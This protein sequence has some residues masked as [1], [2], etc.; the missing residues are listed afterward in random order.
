MKSYKKNFFSV[1]PSVLKR[2]TVVTLCTL[3]MGLVA[4]M[5]LC[6]VLYAQQPMR[7]SWSGE[8]NCEYCPLDSVVVTHK[9]SGE[10]VVFR[11]P[12]TMYVSG[13]VDVKPIIFKT[14]TSMKTIPNPFSDKVQVEFSLPHSSETDMLVCDMLGRAIIRQSSVLE[15]GTHR[16]NLSLPAGMYTF[17]L[18]T[19]T[20]KQSVRLLSENRENTAPQ[21]VYVDATPN[22][23]VT[24]FQKAHKSGEDVPFQ[25]GDTLI[26][27]G[28]I[29]D[30]DVFQYK[31][32]HTVVITE[33]THITFAFFGIVE[34][35]EIT[36]IDDI[37]TNHNPKLFCCYKSA[38][39]VP[40]MTEDDIIDFIDADSFE[41]ATVVKTNEFLLITTQTELD[42]LL[43]C[44][45]SITFP[46]VD[47]E[48]QT[49]L[50]AIG[51]TPTPVFSII[52]PLSAIQL[53]DGHLILQTEMRLANIFTLGKVKWM[54][55][56]NKP[57]LKEQ[58]SLKINF[59]VY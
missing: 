56:I 10:K 47:F 3:M 18:Q 7:L 17:S 8:L 21:M 52:S 16:V 32:K 31:E 9:S 26:M 57:L 48:R 2:S 24:V 50:L 34:T 27:Q 58:I 20:D 53:Y 25:Y 46:E 54:V 41:I 15:K 30:T 45:D 1:T 6:S 35:V 28:F 37:F 23:E 14:E 49:L 5:L 11:Y 22:R 43:A 29:S 42:S 4:N 51:E 13:N 40:Y 44:T 55:L 19:A 12:D 39:F 59:F 38:P 36:V 33:D